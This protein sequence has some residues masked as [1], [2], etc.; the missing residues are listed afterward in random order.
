MSSNKKGALKNGEAIY[1]FWGK[2]FDKITGLDPLGHQNA[3]EKIYT[4]I[5]PGITNLTNRIRYYGFYCWL[6]VEY[7]RINQDKYNEKDQRIFIRRAELTIALVMNKKKPDASQITGSNKAKDIL[8]NSKNKSIIDLKPYTDDPKSNNSYW[9]YSTGAFGQYYEASIRLLGLIKEGKKDGQTIYTV[10]QKKEYLTGQ[11]LANSFNNNLKYSAKEIF[12]N[13]IDKGIL[14]IKD[15]DLLYESFN[16]THITYGSDEWHNYYNL[17]HGFDKPVTEKLSDNHRNQT[18]QII[19]NKS[20]KLAEGITSTNLLNDLFEQVTSQTFDSFT[21]EFGWFQYRLNEF[22]QYS[23]GTIFWSLLNYLS[24]KHNGICKKENL[25][26]EFI[27]L[28]CKKS[29]IDLNTTFTDLLKPIK[30]HSIQNL[31]SK[32]DQTIKSHNDIL[33]GRYALEI[34]LMLFNMQEERL[35][36]FFNLLNNKGLTDNGGFLNKTL[37][38]KKHDFFNGTIKT[39]L[40]WFIHRE[41]LNRHKIVALN[42]LGSGSRSTLKFET[43]GDYILYDDNFTPTLTSPRMDTLFKI[44]YDL[45][46]LDL[47]VTEKYILKSNLN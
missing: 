28:V 11:K 1:P 37:Q 42:K 44:L 40:T 29:D 9:K 10:T 5:L 47:S 20:K 23:C 43:N 2:Q 41:I 6:L 33:A 18:I 7:A 35:T 19:L 36:R 21:T 13:V 16:L 27:E 38:I 45:Q 30:T 14:Q 32:I 46:I 26:N 25:I 31:I 12:L 17:L 15:I 24:T 34:L 3:S 4:S 22:W 39:F 8:D